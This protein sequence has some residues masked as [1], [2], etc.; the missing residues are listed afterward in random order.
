MPQLP[1]PQAGAPQPPAGAQPVVVEAP[2]AVET[3]K[4]EICFSTRVLAHAGQ[5]V[6]SLQ[7]R[8]SFSKAW[9]QSVQ[10]YS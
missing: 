3:A 4:V 6:A 9:E 2:G 8:I 5:E 1:P 7:R 10:R